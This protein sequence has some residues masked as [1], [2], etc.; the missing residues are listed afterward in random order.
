MPTTPGTRTTIELT[1][2]ER[3]LVRNALET[4]LSDFGHENHD[5]IVATRQVIA[6]LA[7]TDTA[8]AAVG[9]GAAG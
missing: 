2:A 4:Y 6:K 1:E 9:T 8:T 7:A 3:R 5:L